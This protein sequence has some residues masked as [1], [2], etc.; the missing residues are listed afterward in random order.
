LRAKKLVDVED[1]LT[2][3]AAELARQ[4]PPGRRALLRSLVG[5]A[6]AELLGGATRPASFPK[7]APMWTPG[8]GRAGGLSD[9]PH[10]DALMVGAAIER[11][12]LAP[13]PCPVSYDELTF[14][15][16]FALDV[17]GALRAALANVANLVL[18]HGRLASRPSPRL[19]TP[20]PSP[21]RQSNGR[22]GAWRLE[23]WI[24]PTFADHAQ[25]ERDVEVAVSAIRK[26]LY[27]AGAYG[28]VE[29]DPAPQAL[30]DERAEYAA[31]RAGLEWLAAELAGELETRAPLPPRAA[32]LPWAG[33]VD[34]EPVRDVFAPGARGVY[35]SAEAA[36]LEG[37]RATGRRR[38]IAGGRVYARAAARLERDEH[39]G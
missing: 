7:I 32:A 9:P 27:P 17:T 15:L 8:M 11:L 13:P 23:R 5:R 4:G 1:L 16:G 39:E 37:S 34:A 22:P 36:M 10:P 38:P 19:E 28:V 18:V 21:K 25:A 33:D 35:D 14:G 2:W 12:R 20:A 26:G 6:D 30:V 24:E 29:C 3:A 31:W